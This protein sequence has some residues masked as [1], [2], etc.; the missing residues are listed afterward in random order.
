M[1]PDSMTSKRPGRPLVPVSG[2]T[3]RKQLWTA[4]PPLKV[5]SLPFLLPPGKENRASSRATAV[6]MATQIV[7]VGAV[8][9]SCLLPESRLSC[10][11]ENKN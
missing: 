1:S 7:K 9:T 4:V 6:A 3:R 8:A 5:C 11:N 2:W 10:E